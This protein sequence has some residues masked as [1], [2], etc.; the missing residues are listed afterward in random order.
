MDPL[1]RQ[2]ERSKREG[3]H[4]KTCSGKGGGVVVCCVCMCHPC[5]TGGC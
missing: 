5:K 1:Y 2:R 4:V 3:E